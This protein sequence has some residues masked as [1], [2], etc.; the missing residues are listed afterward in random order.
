VRRVT[1]ESPS[2]DL[3]RL[4]AMSDTLMWR[5][6]EQPI[7]SAAGASSRRLQYPSKKRVDFGCFSR[8]SVK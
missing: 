8:T 1:L 2:V 7:A 6:R 5:P 4:S 3:S